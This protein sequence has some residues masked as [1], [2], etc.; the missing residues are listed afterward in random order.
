MRPTPKAKRTRRP[1]SARSLRLTWTKPGRAI[2]CRAS[3]TARPRCAIWPISLA[4]R[5]HPRLDP[6]SQ[7][8]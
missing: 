3:S 4:A 8:R 2:E 7:C 1:T 5:N 6:Q